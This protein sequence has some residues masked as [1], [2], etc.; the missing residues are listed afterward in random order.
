MV[1]NRHEQCAEGTDDEDEI[2]ILADRLYPFK[3]VVG[4]VETGLDVELV[5]PAIGPKANDRDQHQR[6]KEKAKDCQWSSLC[7]CVEI[8]RYG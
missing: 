6:S 2:G 3:T 7:R 5:N 4:K 1:S 8:G